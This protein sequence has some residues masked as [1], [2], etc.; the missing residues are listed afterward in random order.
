MYCMAQAGA[1]NG[2]F[3][4]ADRVVWQIASI[5]R[6]TFPKLLAKG[7]IAEQEGKFSITAAGLKAL[8][9]SW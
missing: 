7:L 2:C 3:V 4:D 1:Y 5:R 6:Q 8:E 9:D